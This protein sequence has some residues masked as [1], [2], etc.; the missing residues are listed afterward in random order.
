ML[1]TTEKTERSIE[2]VELKPDQVKE[3]R[4]SNRYKMYRKNNQ[5]LSINKS[6]NSQHNSIVTT[7]RDTLR[8]SKNNNIIH[9]NQEPEPEMYESVE[10]TPR[11]AVTH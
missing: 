1:K 2:K 9:I 3:T 11:S 8:S 7:P 5:V 4:L 6:K 10:L